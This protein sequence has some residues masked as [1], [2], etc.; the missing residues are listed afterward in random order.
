MQG[1]FLFG[2]GYRVADNVGVNLDME[3]GATDDAPDMR[4]FIRVPIAFNLF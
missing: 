1:S 4:A 3:I 2:M